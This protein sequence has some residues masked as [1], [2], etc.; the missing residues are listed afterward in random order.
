M[1]LEYKD[2]SSGKEAEKTSV[3]TRSRTVINTRKR[4]KSIAGRR[5]NETAQA[6]KPTK[7]HKQSSEIRVQRVQQCNLTRRRTDKASDA[8]TATTVQ[9]GA[10]AT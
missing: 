2:T 1:A 9:C 10:A 6:A 5:A 8:K 7:T 4:S 3:N